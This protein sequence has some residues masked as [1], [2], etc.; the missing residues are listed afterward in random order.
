[1]KV[2]TK[3]Q[4]VSLC[5]LAAAAGFVVHPLTDGATPLGLWLYCLAPYVLALWFVVAPWGEPRAQGI[6]GS[7]VSFAFLVLTYL[8]WYSAVFRPT[9]A[10]PGLIFVVLPIYLVAGAAV[11][12]P[13]SYRI[14]K[15]QRTKAQ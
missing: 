1:M 3:I 10:R 14:L 7:I 4:W 11:A 12:W 9:G 13:L 15:A 2:P 6:S 5:A 8:A